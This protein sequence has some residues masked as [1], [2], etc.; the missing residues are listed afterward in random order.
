MI[1]KQKLNEPYSLLQIGA[2]WIISPYHVI[3]SMQH[4]MSYQNHTSLIIIIPISFKRRRRGGGGNDI[5][6]KG[7]DR[8]CKT[9]Q[10]KRERERER[11]P[12]LD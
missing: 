3:D 2:E 5:I 8:A 11:H 6:K 10:G 4:V 7:R 1:L 12:C 9:K